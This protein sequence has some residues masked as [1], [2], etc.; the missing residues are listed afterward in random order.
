MSSKQNSENQHTG[1]ENDSVFC[2]YEDEKKQKFESPS[3]TKMQKNKRLMRTLSEHDFSDIDLFYVTQTYP[4]F[5]AEDAMEEAQKQL[6]GKNV[7]SE[8]LN[9]RTKKGCEKKA[10]KV[11]REAYG[12]KDDL[13]ANGVLQA[14]DVLS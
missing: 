12:K 3:L 6:D 14:F 4:D 7:S 2:C 11:K 13:D 5:F 9:I 10:N 8:N 1:K